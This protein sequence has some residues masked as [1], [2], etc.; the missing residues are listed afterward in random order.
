MYTPEEIN[1]D[2]EPENDALEYD[3]PFQGCSV[4]SGEPC[5]WSALTL[6]YTNP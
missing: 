3:V 1:I 6:C 2:I 4:F 5:Y